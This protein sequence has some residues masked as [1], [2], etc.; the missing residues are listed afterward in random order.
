MESLADSLGTLWWSVLCFVAG[1]A[2][3]PA[4]WKWTYSMLPW[5]KK[6]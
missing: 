2:I 3:G 1:A 4:L 6:D 5:T